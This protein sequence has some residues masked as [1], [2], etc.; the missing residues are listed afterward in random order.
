MKRESLNHPILEQSFALI[1]A[2]VG[3]HN[4]SGDEYAIARRIIHTTA[5]FDYQ[6]VTLTHVN[7]S[8]FLHFHRMMNDESKVVH[9]D[10]DSFEEEP[11]FLKLVAEG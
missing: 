6:F 9:V 10:P 1:D 8:L 2:E 7:N 4:L 11:P 5:D 3:E